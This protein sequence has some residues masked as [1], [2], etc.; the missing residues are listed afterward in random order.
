MKTIEIVT[1]H[2]IVVTQELASVG[3]RIG[4][5]IVDA[6]ILLFYIIVVSMLS[7][8]NVT[9]RYLG[10]GLVSIFYHL[11]WEI[12]NHGQS[13]GKKLMN[14]RVVSIRG[15]SP[16]I[17]DLLQRWA[18]RLVDITFTFGTLAILSIVTSINNQR[19][20]DLLGETT[21]INL[22]ARRR[23]DLQSLHQ[24]KNQPEEIAYPAIVRYSDTDMLL[25]KETLQR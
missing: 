2:N 16:S 19:I 13:P 5:F 8:G 6:I 22:R 14:I 23:I 1:A 4:A 12:F 10:I 11:I 3:Q 9:V 20:G 21:V 24:L 25:V 15:I 17:Q 7:Q 18:F